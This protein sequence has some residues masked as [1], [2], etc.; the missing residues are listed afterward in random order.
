MIN[1]FEELERNSIEHPEEKTIIVRPSPRT[2]ADVLQI[3]SF[4]GNLELVDICTSRGRE[5]GL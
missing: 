2:R 5:D 3:S 4:V 1:M